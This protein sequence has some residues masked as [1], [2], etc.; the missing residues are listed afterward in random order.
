MRFFLFSFRAKVIIE[1]RAAH[2][3]LKRGV[4]SEIGAM[5]SPIY[6]YRVARVFSG[7]VLDAIECCPGWKRR[8]TYCD[9]YGISRVCVCVDA[10]CMVQK[11][12][13]SAIY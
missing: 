2:K 9:G 13:R 12:N 6:I 5:Q 8:N 1:I 3:R 7:H 10:F 4:D 11:G